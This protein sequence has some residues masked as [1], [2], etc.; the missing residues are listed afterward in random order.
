MAPTTGEVG[1]V[2]VRVIVWATVAAL[3]TVTVYVLTVEPFWAVTTTRM[4]FSP[5]LRDPLNGVVPVA[6]MY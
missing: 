6:P 2:E 4:V 3:V 1:E 5:T